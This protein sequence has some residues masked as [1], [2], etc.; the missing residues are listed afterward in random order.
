MAPAL[1]RSPRVQGHPEYVVKTLLHGLAGPIEG[2]TYPGH[3]MVPMGENSDEWVAAVTS[4]VRS[5]FGNAASTVTPE[6]VEKVRAA[7]ADQAA[8]YTYEELAASLPRPLEPQPTWKATASHREPVRVGGSAR[9]E[10]AFT[11]EGWTTGAAQ[12]PG[13]WFQI[14]L[15]EPATVSGLT[16]N[17]PSKGRRGDPPQ[18]VYPRGY[19]VE[20]SADGHGW[21]T[22]AEGPGTDVTSVERADGLQI[23]HDPPLR[24]GSGEAPPHHADGAR[25]GALVDAV[26]APL[27]GR[28]LRR[29]LTS[30]LPTSA[31]DP[32]AL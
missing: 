19:R 3:I 30:R 9:P 7:T 10:G 2:E 12:E 11:L 28:A 20:V 29:G 25:G 27:R 17:A 6:Y 16:F 14:E 4:Y 31:D 18:F 5:G 21:S 15:T 22:V 1:A 23:H 8:P 13:M 32:R 24:A 26:A